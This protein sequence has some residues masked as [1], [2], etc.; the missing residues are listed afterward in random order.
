MRED[1][2]DKKAADVLLLMSGPHLYVFAERR[3]AR[4]QERGFGRHSRLHD[5]FLLNPEVSKVACGSDRGQQAYKPIKT[6]RFF[7][8]FDLWPLRD[9][10]WTR[11][12]PMSFALRTHFYTLNVR[13]HG[14]RGR[15]SRH[16]RSPTRILRQLPTGSVLFASPAAFTACARVGASRLLTGHCAE[17]GLEGTCAMACT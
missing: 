14:S 15:R 5:R 3:T 11:V 4:G 1:E 13:Q 9:L 6:G 17:A 7:F 10:I 16:A 12:V 8:A 2:K